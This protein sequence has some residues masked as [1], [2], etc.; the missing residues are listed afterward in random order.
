MAEKGG[1]EEE[2]IIYGRGWL[3]IIYSIIII[4]IGIAGYFVYKN[5]NNYIQI[6]ILLPLIHLGL[7]GLIYSVLSKKV[8]INNE[9]IT[10]YFANFKRYEI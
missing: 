7:I 6:Y 1:T 10:Y 2:E 3:G 9:K 8:I 5:S 4:F